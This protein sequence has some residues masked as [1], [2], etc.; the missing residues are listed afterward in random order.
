MK[1]FKILERIIDE[2]VAIENKKLIS[3]NP[4]Q[5]EQI[6]ARLGSMAGKLDEVIKNYDESDSAKLHL[7]SAP[8]PYQR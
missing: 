1:K 4:E 2:F 6:K 3:L 7:S 8:A 5:K